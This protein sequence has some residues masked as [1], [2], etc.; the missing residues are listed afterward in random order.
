MERRFAV[1][2]DELMAACQVEPEM[3]EGLTGRLEEFVEPFAQAVFRRRESKQHA[4]TYVAGLL[5]D[6]KRKNT[7]SIAYRHDQGRQ[8]L[9]RFIG[10]HQWDHRP[11][12]TE[13]V[14]QVGTH[15]GQADAVIVFDPSGFAKKRGRFGWCPAAMAGAIG[16]GR[17][18]AGRD[19]HGLR[20]ARGSCVGR[21]AVVSSAR[22]GSGQTA[23]PEMRRAEGCSLCDPPSVGPGHAGRTHRS[24]ASHVGGRRRRNG[25]FDP[26]SQGFGRAG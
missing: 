23:S 2:L 9:Q 26:F 13:L 6:L 3:F 25:P 14:R 11:L 19:L 21:H 8:G 7:E 24:V 18:R 16:E 15:L 17:Q 5:S 4:Q 1:R 22:M 10:F 12:V 20:F